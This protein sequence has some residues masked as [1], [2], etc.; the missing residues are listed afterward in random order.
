VSGNLMLDQFDRLPSAFDPNVW[1]GCL[2]QESCASIAK[3]ANTKLSFC[4]FDH[5]TSSS[6]QQSS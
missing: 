2:S 1:T 5:G 4:A 6:I 3:A